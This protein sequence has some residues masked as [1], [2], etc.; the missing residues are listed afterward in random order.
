MLAAVFGV[1]MYRIIVVALLYASDEDI[2]RSNAKLTTTATAALI[3]LI[4]IM[5]L[6]KVGTKILKILTLLL[7]AVYNR[8][9]Q[10]SSVLDTPMIRT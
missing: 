8:M 7:F 2:V 6:N 4:L 1:I 3:N 10:E 5:F 9:N